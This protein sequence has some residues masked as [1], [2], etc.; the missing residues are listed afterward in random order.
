MFG[1]KK[2]PTETPTARQTVLIVDDEPDILDSLKGLLVGSLKDLRVL[3]SQ[4]GPQG[5][6][7]MG[8]EP[9]DLILSDYRMPGMNG[10]EFLLKARERAPEVPRV[11]ITAFPDLDLAM[12][13][14]NEANIENF[15]TKP[16][17]ANQV[18][19][20]VRDLLAERRARLQRDRSFARSFDQLRKEVESRR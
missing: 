13:A 1:A 5:L 12:R 10:L 20:R 15:L 3:T 16:F 7:L 9:I 11:L 2:A 18:I 14:I 17:D 19:E 8:L 6:T 4:S